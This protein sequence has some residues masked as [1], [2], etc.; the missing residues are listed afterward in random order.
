VDL[1][2][3]RREIDASRIAARGREMGAIPVLYTAA[4]DARIRSV[5]LERSVPSYEAIARH[6]IHRQ[7]WENAVAGALRHYDL[8]DLERAMSLRRVEWIE[9][10]Y[11]NGRLMPKRQR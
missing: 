9:P 2:A 8:P 10:L 3:G 11:P 6:R 7:Q 5:A 4:F 1:L